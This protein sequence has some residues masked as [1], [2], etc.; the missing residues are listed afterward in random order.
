MYYPSCFYH[1]N[2]CFEI[3]R[4]DIAEFLRTFLIGYIFQPVPGEELPSGYPIS[5]KPAIPVP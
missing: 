3:I 2:R 4:G 5:T 1:P